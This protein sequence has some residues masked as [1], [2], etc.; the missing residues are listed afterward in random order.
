MA[1][2]VYDIITKR[3]EDALNQ[4]IIPWRKP[5]NSTKFG[6]LRNAITKHSY[7]GI[8][9]FILNMVMLSEGY[10]DPRWITYKQI[11]AKGGKLKEKQHG[12]PVVFWTFLDR[13]DEETGEPKRIPFLRYYTV[14]N[15]EQC[16]DLNLP[17]LEHATGEFNAIEAAEKVVAGMPNP[18]KISH[19]EQDRAFYRPAT[20]SITMPKHEQFQSENGY[21]A[22]MFHELGHSTGHES[23]L[24]RKTVVD[25]CDNSNANRGREELIAEFTSAFL[26]GHVGIE[27]M[28]LDN[29]AAYIQSWVG[30][31]KNDAQAVTVAA[32]QAQKAAD[33]ILGLTEEKSE[34]KPK[35]SKSKAKTKARKAA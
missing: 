19:I 26:C 6:D 31:I 4:G 32:S 24:N 21:Y 28:E 8:N 3:I 15:V 34:P 5:W 18:P 20:D 2:K 23:R 17:E 35:K 14:F 27:D 13:K 10:E 11:Q 16:E 22:T 25:V 29:S 12:A 9:P 1:N 7:T 30:A 33:H